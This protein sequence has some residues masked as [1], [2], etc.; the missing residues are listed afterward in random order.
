MQ[1]Q[2]STGRLEV[3]TTR[4]L[5]RPTRRHAA[6]IAGVGYLV[7]FVLSVFAN[8]MVRT[9][10][11]D[12]DDPTATASNIHDSETLF[13]FG[14]VAFLIVF[15]VDVVVAWALFVLFEDVSVEMSRLSAWFRLVYTVFLGVAT[16]FFF[17]ALELLSG[18]DYLGA[19]DTAQLDTQA[20]VALDAFNVAWLVGLVAFGLHLIVLGYLLLRSSVATKWL[21]YVLVVAGAAYITDTLANA[22]L[23]N[24]DDFEGLFLMIVVLPSVIGELWLTIWLLTR[25]GRDASPSLARA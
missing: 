18:A 5:P 23:S 20:L 13:R 4:A 19:F 14:L 25:G 7:I 22:L 9:N 12:S 8:F 15:V 1:V 11:I 21:G 17:V 24:Y 6:I 10:L 2:S 16:V 3:P